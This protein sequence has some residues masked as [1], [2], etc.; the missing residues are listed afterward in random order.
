MLSKEFKEFKS[1][2][3][4]EALNW[5]FGCVESWEEAWVTVRGLQKTAAS[6]LLPCVPRIPTAPELLHF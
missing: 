5:S 1:T 3:V 6:L 4:Q 2:G